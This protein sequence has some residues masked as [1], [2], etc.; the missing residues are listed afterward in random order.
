MDHHQAVEQDLASRFLSGELAPEEREA[1]E[2]H[3][4]D[5]PECLDAMESSDGLRRGL[6]SVAA[7][8]A[9]NGR[10]LPLERPRSWRRGVTSAAAI[11]ATLAIAVGGIDLVR[12]RRELARVSRVAS[13]LTEQSGR[14]QSLVAAMSNRL[15][16]L[17]N[18]ARPAAAGRSSAPV[19]MLTTVRGAGASTPSNRVVLT[20]APDLIVL[21][22]ELDDADASG[23]FRATLRDGQRRERWQD[24]RLTASTPGAL[25]IALPAALLS[26]GDYVLDVDHQPAGSTAWAPAGRYSF[27]VL[28]DR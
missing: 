6:R 17:E 2:E 3:F 11:A 16:Q 18:T 12:T 10:I 8:N 9:Q 15:N 5:C 27:R 1:F 20:G 24:D 23:R 14:A 28:K 25:G 4:I 21:S 26:D 7:K 22:L 13:D 19:F